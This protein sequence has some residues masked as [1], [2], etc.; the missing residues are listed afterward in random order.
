[1]ASAHGPTFGMWIVS[2][3]LE[4]IL[5]GCGML[6]AWLYF[7]WYPKDHWGV[8]SMVGILIILESLQVS[9]FFA[10]TYRAFIENFG[11][12]DALFIITWEDSTQLITGFLSAFVVQ[13]YFASCIYA[14]DKRKKFATLIIVALALTQ[15]G[16][17]IAQMTVTQRLGNLA[18]LG[19]TKVITTLQAGA[20]ALCDIVITIMLVR[21][22]DKQRSG[23]KSTNS[24][25][26]MLII[27]AVNR[28]MLTA[29]CAVLYIILF[30]SKPGTFYFFLGLILS[31]K[32]YM[33]SALATLNTRQHIL[34]KSSR[35]EWHSVQLDTLT[36]S[37]GMDLIV[38]FQF[39]SML[40]AKLFLIG[41]IRGLPVRGKNRSS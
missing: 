24:M 12:P 20:A 21:T 4:S 33:N 22:L 38:T 7:H 39:K 14:L 36:T 5:Y 15:I 29:F 3:F 6:Q 34:Q 19:N 31:S 9:L 16:A 18:K 37:S 17:G 30:W 10:S 35:S 11:D 23:I 32:L 26:N 41:R 27:N 40:I 2:L 8:K 28:G 25:L 1:M 13:I